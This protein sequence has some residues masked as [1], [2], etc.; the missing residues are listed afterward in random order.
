MSD[1]YLH[2]VM[3]QRYKK[4]GVDPMKNCGRDVD[5]ALQGNVT[6]FKAVYIEAVPHAM[7]P[8]DKAHRG[9]INMGNSYQK[10]SNLF[11]HKQLSTL[12]DSM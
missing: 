9:N 5:G 12:R 8:W 1:E 6:G 3:V 4:R 2:Q 11:M 7:C 10:E